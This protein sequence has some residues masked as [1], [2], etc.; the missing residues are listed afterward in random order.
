V[1]GVKQTLLDPRSTW[2]DPESYDRKARKL[3]RMFRDNFEQFA[4]DAGQAV[5]D[6]GPQV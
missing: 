2:S 1:P 3:A 6:A 5:A 4:E